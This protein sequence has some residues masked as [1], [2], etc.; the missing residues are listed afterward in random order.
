M[1]AI[2]TFVYVGDIQINGGHATVSSRPVAEGAG[3]RWA[4]GLVG[5]GLNNPKFS[6]SYPY[7]PATGQPPSSP[8]YYPYW[9]G[10]IIAV[11]DGTATGPGTGNRQ[12]QDTGAGWTTNQHQGRKLVLV[13]GTGSGQTRRIVSNTTDTLTVHE[14]WDTN[15]DA[16]TVYDIKGEWVVYHHT[17]GTDPNTL[18]PVVAGAKGDNW[19]EVGGGIT[20]TTMMIAE[21]HEKYGGTAP[22]FKFFKGVFGSS[23]GFSAGANQL[24]TTGF[25][26]FELEWSYAVGTAARGGNTLDVE[27]VILDASYEDIRAS[28]DTSTFKEDLQTTL[29]NFR[30]AFPYAH[31]IVVNHRSDICSDTAP[32]IAPLIRQ[33]IVDI[34]ALAENENCSVFDMGTFAELASGNP[35][36]TESPLINWVEGEHYYRTTDYVDAGTLLVQHYEMTIDVTPSSAT[37]EVPVIVFFGDS[38]MSGLAPLSDVSNSDFTRWTGAAWSS[39]TWPT[40]GSFTDWP[41]IATVPDVFMFTQK[42]PHTVADERRITA[43]PAADQVT[44]AG[45][46]LVAT[47]RDS[48]VYI[49]ENTTGYGQTLRINADPS[50]GTTVTLLDPLTAGAPLVSIANNG[51]IQLLTGSHTIASATTDTMLNTTTITKTALTADFTCGPDDWVSI[52]ATSFA[53]YAAIGLTRRVVSATA[54]TVTVWPALTDLPASGDGIRELVASG[55]VRGLVDLS[56]TS[57]TFKPLQ[58]FHDGSYSYSG[59]TDYPNYIAIPY[60]SPNAHATLNYVNGIPEASW[61]IKSAVDGPIYCINE[62][63]GGAMA[64]SFDINDEH[65][66]TDGL[67]GLAYD[68]KLKDFRPNVPTNLYDSLTRKLEVAQDLIEA[69]GGTMNVIGILSNVGT[70]DAANQ[71]RA[72]AY[73][74]AMESTIDGLRNFIVA[75]GMTTR[76]ADRIPFGLTGVNAAISVRAYKD[77]VNA[78]M[79]AIAAEKPG[80]FYVDSTDFDLQVD[81]LHLSA[82]GQVSWG[83]AFY[84][85]WLQVYSD[86]ATLEI[87]SGSGDADANS[88][89]S[90]A[91]ANEFHRVRNGN[92]PAWVSATDEAKR[93]ALRRATYVL[94]LRY[95]SRWA[96]E[97][98]SSDQA[99]DWPRRYVMDRAGG[100]YDS[101]EIPQRLI[102]ATASLALLHISGE[103]IMPATETGASISSESSSVGSLSQ[104]ISYIG[105]KPTLLQIPQ[106][107]R[108]LGTAGLINWGGLGWGGVSW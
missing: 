48:W 7:N 10:N 79:Q 96:G 91:Q 100:Y 46:N 94:D 97:R 54:T 45:A 98:A 61:Q 99:L 32:G 11:N 43:T 25:E 26:G 93:T 87:E 107:D 14:D 35:A 53:S 73:K 88:Y 68:I 56:T 81:Q 63:Y 92:P 64:T 24:A 34:V 75:N 83:Q 70:N 69:G 36:A 105:G 89:C 15:P 39:Q 30:D 20:P 49:S 16:T 37:G 21:L 29:D 84:N 8:P 4:Q 38:N 2:P 80:V 67:I 1:A 108:I 58:F 31:I 101:S 72:A 85:G 41:K 78:A 62:S 13:G 51:S 55:T 103:D 74:R 77:T 65:A 22:Y 17:D 33:A 23:S 76:T 27:C 50:G 82:E 40:G 59:P 28:V 95:G 42:M 12:L 5:L 71:D 102:D 57:C 104:S 90:L 52:I 44:M 60:R 106:V 18:V 6:R 19:Y 9:D 47:Q 3:S 66:E 86:V